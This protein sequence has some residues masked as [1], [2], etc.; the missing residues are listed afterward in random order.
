MYK[1]ALLRGKTNQP[2]K[3][4]ILN[5]PYYLNNVLYY[6]NLAVFLNYFKRENI[7]ILLY[8]DLKK[9]PHN[10]LKE[11]YNFIGVSEHYPDN[12]LS[13]I[14]YSRKP[15]I[16]ILDKIIAY[17]GDFLRRKNLYKIKAFL[18]S[19]GWV[20]KIKKLNTAQ[21]TTENIDAELLKYIQEQTKEDLQHLEKLSKKNLDL[22]KK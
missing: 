3:E 7:L 19:F 17:S 13:K 5:E 16:A 6:K 20:D 11:I 8:D 14:N 18:Q 15:K 10:F 12:I 22:W 1:L 4:T 21:E 9:D 2:I